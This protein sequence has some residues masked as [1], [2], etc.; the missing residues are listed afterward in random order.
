MGSVFSSEFTCKWAVLVWL[1]WVGWGHAGGSQEIVD[2]KICG[3]GVFLSFTLCLFILNSEC[4]PG[5]LLLAAVPCS[6]LQCCGFS[7]FSS[8]KASSRLGA[9][10]SEAAL[11]SVEAANSGAHAL[12]QFHSRINGG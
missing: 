2:G 8:R 3:A 11:D 7:V 6:I 9:P 4:G 1:W 5:S 10:S 12:N